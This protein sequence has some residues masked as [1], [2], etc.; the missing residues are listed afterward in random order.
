MKIMDAG[1]R[2]GN[3]DLVTKSIAA[4]ADIDITPGEEHLTALTEA[5]VNA[6]RVPDAIRT[7]SNIRQSGLPV[8]LDT[9]RSIVNVLTTPNL[10]DQAF[11]AAE[12]LHKA[13]KPVDIVVLD[14]LIA[15]SVCLGDLQRARA[16]QLAIKDFGLTPT[17][18]SFN[19]ILDACLIH[20]FHD[21][22]EIIMK[23]MGEVEGLKPNRATYERII[24]LSVAAE[25]SYE[26][27]F[28][29]L[30]AMKTAGMMPTRATYDSLLRRCLEAQDSRWKMVSEEMQ[31]LG[32]TMTAKTLEVARKHNHPHAQG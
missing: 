19:L 22:G 31:E 4:L 10:I 21:L 14:A 18:D 11:Y 15:A 28:F 32:Y 24:L 17:I 29:Y 2:L 8:T 27:A 26:D 12:D 20:K 7:I 16:N 3:P 30:E 5:F 1:A 13:G 9:A 23:E 6:S 25:T